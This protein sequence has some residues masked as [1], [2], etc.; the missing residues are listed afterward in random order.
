MFA[1]ESMLND[2]HVKD[3]TVGIQ[4]V[5]S[6]LVMRNCTMNGGGGIQLT[7]S[8]PVSLTLD[9]ASISTSSGNTINADLLNALD[10]SV[11]NSRLSASYRYRQVT[12]LTCRGHLSIRIINSTMKSARGKTV[13]TGGDVNLATVAVENSIFTGQVDIGYFTSN[14]RHLVCFYSASA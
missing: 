14:L 6:S 4:L 12:K 1:V 11:T 10:L 2:V 3:A 8:E 5:N 9:N 13:E 7:G